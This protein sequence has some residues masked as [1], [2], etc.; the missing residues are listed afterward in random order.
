M[1]SDC[2][3]ITTM[4]VILGTN[5]TGKTTVEKNIAKGSGQRVLVITPDDR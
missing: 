2:S 1:A 5:G 4:T 3:N